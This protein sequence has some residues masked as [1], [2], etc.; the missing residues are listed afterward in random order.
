MIDDG[1]GIE[2]TRLLQFGGGALLIEHHGSETKLRLEGLDEWVMGP[3][4]LDWLVN[5]LKQRSEA[6]REEYE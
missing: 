1:T 3:D 6:L 2:G 5:I 4:G